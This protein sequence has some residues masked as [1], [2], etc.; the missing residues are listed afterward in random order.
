MVTLLKKSECMTVAELSRQMGI[1]HMAVRQHLMALEKRG[2]AS[3]TVK[4][5]GVGRPVFLYRLTGR[6]DGIFPKTYG[7]FINSMLRAVEKLDGK[8]RMDNLFKLRKDYLL[9][10]KKKTLSSAKTLSQKVTA[11]AGMLEADGYMVELEEKNGSFT[12]RQF[13]CPISEIASE[14]VEPCKY[15]LQF[16]RELLEAN[17]RR[18]QC[19]RKGAHSCT[20]IIPTL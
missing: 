13:N 2:I 14:F 4:K 5:C 17:V 9:P 7:E 3:Y 16:Y 1:T 15:E 19:Q 20:Y 11:L 10:A 12:L 8:T 6:A 18:K